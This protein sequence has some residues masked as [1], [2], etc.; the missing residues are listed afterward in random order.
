MCSA[1][2]PTPSWTASMSWVS[3]VMLYSPVSSAWLGRLA[4]AVALILPS[5]RLGH[6]PAKIEPS[7]NLNCSQQQELCHCDQPAQFWNDASAPGKGS[8]PH[9]WWKRGILEIWRGWKLW[10][11]RWK[12]RVPSSPSMYPQSSH[13]ASRR[14]VTKAW[15]FDSH[16]LC[17]DCPSERLNTPWDIPS[18]CEARNKFTSL[19]WMQTSGLGSRSTLVASLESSRAFRKS[20]KQQNTERQFLSC[21]GQCHFEEG[22]ERITQRT[23]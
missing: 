8:H 21:F 2:R 23:R 12:S 3:W 15:S 5:G 22:E 19:A 16:A 14:L 18:S 17:L 7:E 1:K 4:F 11:V 10:K 13:R 6:R 9:C 20:E